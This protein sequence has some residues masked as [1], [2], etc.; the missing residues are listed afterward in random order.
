MKT[1]KLTTLL[2]MAVTGLA[3]SQVEIKEHV[4]EMDCHSDSVK[5]DGQLSGRNIAD[6]I[7][8]VCGKQKAHILLD[9]P[10][11]SLDYNVTKK[12]ASKALFIG[13]KEGKEMKNT[14]DEGTYL[15]RLYLMGSASQSSES[16]PY[17]LKISLGN[18]RVPKP[19][20]GEDVEQ[21]PD[22]QEGQDNQTLQT[23]FEDTVAAQGISFTVSM[24]GKIMTVKPNGLKVSNSPRSMQ[25]KG[26]VKQIK[27][28]DLD[29]NGAPELF[30]VTKHEST[31]YLY[32]FDTNNK[33]SLID[34]YL[35]SVA[36]MPRYQDVYA[37]RDR[38]TFTEDT[39]ERTFPTFM[40][41]KGQGTPVKLSYSL[42]AGA[43]GWA[44]QLD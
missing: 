41:G 31:E 32:G 28:T 22:Q 35:T 34:I 12:G 13:A 30:V 3:Q 29:G 20:R 27:T 25:V 23:D 24:S 5:V 9:T 8:K 26:K 6:Y 33:G 37:E 15:V 40:P 17:S 16:Y 18:K 39:V 7:F 42:V 1:H 14:L 21:E 43:A 2:L 10:Q 38:Y 11:A 36:N 44:L 4:V 19:P